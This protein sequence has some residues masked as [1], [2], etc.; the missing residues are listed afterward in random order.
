MPKEKAGSKKAKSG[1]VRKAPIKK[2]EDVAAIKTYL[3]A[4]SP[5]WSAVGIAAAVGGAL[6]AAALLGVGPAALAGAAGY[7]AY[8]E[9]SQEQTRD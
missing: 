8:R 4:D 3:P 6:L 7:L 9:M 2:R 5:Q 1:N